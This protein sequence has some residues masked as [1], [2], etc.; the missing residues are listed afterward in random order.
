MA[1][2]PVQIHIVISTDSRLSSRTYM[3]DEDGWY[4]QESAADH[5]EGSPSG[6]AHE[7]EFDLECPQQAVADA[8]MAVHAAFG[9][10]LGPGERLPDLVPV[11]VKQ[12]S[13][14]N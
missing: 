13:T 8:L 2:H 3:R 7:R 12:D 1:Q 9:L 6:T 11:A 4:C 10:M 14:L 5:K